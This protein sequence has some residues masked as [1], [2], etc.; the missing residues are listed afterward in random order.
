M[1]ELRVGVIGIPGK[2]STEALADALEQRTGNR[3]FV[4]IAAEG[5]PTVAR[6]GGEFKCS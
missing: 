1:T 4:R 2:W 5:S 6:V 3:L